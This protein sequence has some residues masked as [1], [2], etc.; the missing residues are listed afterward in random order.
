MS[1]ATN[2][3]IEFAIIEDNYKPSNEEVLSMAKEL[4][5]LKHKGPI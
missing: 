1:I 3:T 5:N 4:W 2:E